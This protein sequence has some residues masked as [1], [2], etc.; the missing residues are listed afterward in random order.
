MEGIDER[1]AH[2]NKNLS[3]TK[4]DLET[5]K[6]LAAEPFDQA[7]K[8]KQ[9]RIRYNEVMD[10]LNPPKEEQILDSDGGDAVQYQRRNRYKSISQQE[11]RQIQEDRM[12][13]YGDHFDEMPVIDYTHVHDMLYV[14]ENLDETQFGVLERIDPAKNKTKADIVVEA[15]GDG[16]VQNIQDLNGRITRLRNFQKLRSVY[17]SSARNGRASAGNAGLGTGFAGSS[18]GSGL[19]GAG[20]GNQDCL[21][22]LRTV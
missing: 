10:I 5:Q 21:W 22:I 9:K 7:E 20:G 13:K 18:N 3:E 2:W 19:P 1:V 15:F 6:Q 12:E 4:S 8:L 17:H 14:F 16:P 11:Y